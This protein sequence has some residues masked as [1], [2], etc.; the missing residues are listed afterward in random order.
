MKKKKRNTQKKVVGWTS[1]P[2]GGA[3]EGP[4]A[5]RGRLRGHTSQ[6]QVPPLIVVR[7]LLSSF[8]VA[9]HCFSQA[10]LLSN[11]DV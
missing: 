1:V 7:C 3:A 6:H 2:P 10:D 4:G 9:L 5:N 11:F 8:C